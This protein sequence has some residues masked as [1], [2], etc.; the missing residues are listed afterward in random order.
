MRQLGPLDLKVSLKLTEKSWVDIFAVRES[1]EIWLACRIHNL[2]GDCSVKSV[3][4]SV[5]K[6]AIAQHC[7]QVINHKLE[8]IDEILGKM[9]NVNLSGRSNE[10]SES[11]DSDFSKIMQQQKHLIFLSKLMKECNYDLLVASPTEEAL[12]HF[13]A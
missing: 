6:N 11:G 5:L 4:I 10:S 3:D 13:L 2:Y 7:V 1:T 9:Q 8:V 12:L